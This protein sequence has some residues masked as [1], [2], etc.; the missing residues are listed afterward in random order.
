M[1]RGACASGNQ[2]LGTHR[3]PPNVA[4]R[5]API[6]RRYD[7]PLGGSP[8]RHL[9]LRATQP[10]LGARTMMTKGPNPHR[11]EG[12]PAPTSTSSPVAEVI[13]GASG[14]MAHHPT[15]RRARICLCGATPPFAA[16]TAGTSS[17]LCHKWVATNTSHL[18]NA[19]THLNVIRGPRARP[20][21][22]QADPYMMRLG[23]GNSEPTAGPVYG[24]HRR[25]AQ[26]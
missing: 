11:A 15:K 10:M 20:S 23:F 21:C 4:Q 17:A 26:H 6:V 22:G 24:F 25:V 13:A 5:N 19:S 12:P 7:R 14:T 18:A 16:L 2:S 9:A 8:P 1:V 3:G